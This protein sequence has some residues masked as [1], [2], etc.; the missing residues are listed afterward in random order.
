MLGR[1]CEYSSLSSKLLHAMGRWYLSWKN[2]REGEEGVSFVSFLSQQR[3]VVRLPPTALFLLG[4]SWEI[5]FPYLK[6]YK[7]YS[8]EGNGAGAVTERQKREILQRVGLDLG[9]LSQ[10]HG[11]H[12]LTAV[13]DPSFLL[14]RREGKVCLR[15][16]WNGGFTGV[17]E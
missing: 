11:P 17:T 14:K 9:L 8:F 6:P 16:P 13:Q 1:I 5:S 4:G 12:S 15:C 7:R 10:T 3:K 2:G